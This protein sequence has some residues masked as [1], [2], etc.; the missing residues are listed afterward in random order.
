VK[1]AQ[2][3]ALRLLAKRE[4]GAY[5]LK[6][7]LLQ[8]GIDDVVANQAIQELKYQNLQSDRR[9]VESYIRSRVTKGFGPEYVLYELSKVGIEENLI[10][11]TL[12]EYQDQ[13]KEIISQISLKKF[14]TAHF[15]S[16]VVKKE[17]QIRFF[18]NRGFNISQID[19]ALS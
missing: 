17:K 12:Q 9:F 14:Q 7:K 6:K 1:E 4:Y 15:L 10:H 16:D 3:V 18:Q 11:E 13:W 2:E 19:E 5:E 8:Q